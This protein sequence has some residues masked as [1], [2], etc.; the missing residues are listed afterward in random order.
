MDYFASIELQA[1]ESLSLSAHVPM[2]LCI[3]QGQAWLTRTHFGGGDEFPLMGERLR[4][5][6]GERIVIES[7]HASAPLSLQWRPQTQSDG[8]MRRSLR[9]LHA[10]WARLTRNRANMPDAV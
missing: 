4:V 5:A 7:L 6:A 10:P 9:Q 8:W 3:T 1:R 2:Q